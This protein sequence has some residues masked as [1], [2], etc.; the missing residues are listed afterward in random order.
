MTPLQAYELAEMFGMRRR[1]Y[2]SEIGQY[3]RSLAQPRDASTASERAYRDMA[4]T[5]AC[6]R[7]AMQELQEVESEVRRVLGLTKAAQKQGGS[8]GNQV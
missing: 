2:D 1:L 8:D 3:E 5:L 4:T 6:R 7:A